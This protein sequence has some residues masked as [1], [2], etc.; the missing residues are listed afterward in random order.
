M[1]SPPNCRR[2]VSEHE[3]IP[4]ALTYLSSTGF[5]L[6]LLTFQGRSE[7]L[8]CNF[9]YH[10]TVF[11][12]KFQL[13]ILCSPN[14]LCYSSYTS[15]AVSSKTQS[16]NSC[17]EVRIW[18]Y[19]FWNIILVY[20]TATAVVPFWSSKRRQPMLFAAAASWRGV[21]PRL[22]PIST[23]WPDLKNILTAFS[24]PSRAAI[25]RDDD[26]RGYSSL[27]CIIYWKRERLHSDLT[28]C[29]LS[30]KCIYKQQWKVRS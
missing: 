22:S 21:Q 15:V 23:R 2:Q 28:A 12:Q 13:L 4:E 29:L 10:D 9:L 26:D 6:N 18:E 17:C 20:G 7:M 5:Y 25:P 14:V 19:Q 3:C 27:N 1:C 8:V 16:Y 30:L 11:W 24:F